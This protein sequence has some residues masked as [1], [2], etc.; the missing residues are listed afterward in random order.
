MI[1]PLL[2]I[3][4]GAI[5][6]IAVAVTD[7]D[8]PVPDHPPDLPPDAPPPAG[9]PKST[10]YRLVDAILPELKK[11][12]DLSGIPLGLLVGWIAK[13]SGGKIAEITKLGE[14]GYFQLIPD[15]YKKLGLDP[16]LLS[17]DA[18]YSINGGLML[19]GTYMGTVDAL[20]VAAKGST[21]FWLLVKLCHTMGS[22][23]TR[24]IVSEAKAAGDAKSWS[25]LESYALDNNAALLHE[26]KHAPA[27]WFPF[28]DAL[29]EVG[30]PFGFG[31]G[32]TLVGGAAFNDIPDPIDCLP[33]I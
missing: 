29:Y 6:L 18:T 22:G 1:F 2:L 24:T 14:V 12:S 3:G 11:A 17:T 16:H 7:S 9:F 20:G 32:T 33:K 5:A 15:E 28:I 25:S 27:K 19:I 10:H 21:Y 13:E 8:G 26:T 30:A 4:A 31:S 23:A